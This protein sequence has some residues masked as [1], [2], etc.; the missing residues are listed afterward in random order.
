MTILLR[1]TMRNHLRRSRP[2][3]ILNVFQR[4][5]LRFFHACGLASGRTSSASARSQCRKGSSIYS[6]SSVRLKMGVLRYEPMAAS[7][8]AVFMVVTISTRDAKRPPY[9]SMGCD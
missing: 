9:E 8:F 5:R 7:L 6:I 1:Q 3:R 4:I 2:E